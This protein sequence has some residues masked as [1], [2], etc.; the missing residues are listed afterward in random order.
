MLHHP[1]WN[2]SGDN[3]LFLNLSGTR[4]PWVSLVHLLGGAWI[5]HDHRPPGEDWEISQEEKEFI[6]Q[7]SQEEVLELLDTKFRRRSHNTRYIRVSKDGQVGRE[8]GITV[9]HDFEIAI[10]PVL[11][12]QYEAFCAA[13]GYR[14][15]AELGRLKGNCYYFDNSTLYELSAEA[16][17]KAPAIDLCYVDAQ[18]YCEWSGFRLP[19]EAE[20]ILAAMITADEAKSYDDWCAF[21]R[22][23]ESSEDVIKL[24]GSEITAT[25]PAPT[26]CVVRRGPW[27]IQP[28]GE[29]VWHSVFRLILPIHQFWGL[30]FRICKRS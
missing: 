24:P 12:T 6:S 18:A 3:H 21:H 28:P 9:D 8:L 23:Y 15:V 1:D 22:R 19:T 26:T 29:P 27:L 17:A 5:L 14:T 11:V 4:R 20:W 25:Q 30:Q 10:Q 7:L 16:R 13:T 2:G